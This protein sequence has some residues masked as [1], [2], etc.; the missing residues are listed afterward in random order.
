MLKVWARAPENPMK[1]TL[2]ISSI[3]TYRDM[4]GIYTKGLQVAT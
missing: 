1:Y 3:H 4:V 2:S